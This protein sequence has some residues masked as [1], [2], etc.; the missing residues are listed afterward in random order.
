[1]PYSAPLVPP[2][3]EVQTTPPEE[4]REALHE[5][6]HGQS[7]SATHLPIIDPG[8]PAVRHTAS[9]HST[10]PAAR[11]RTGASNPSKA[12]PYARCVA[13]IARFSSRANRAAAGPFRVAPD[14]AALTAR[15][16]AFI[17]MM[18]A[19]SGGCREQSGSRSHV[20]DS[21]RS[22][23]TM[24]VTTI[25]PARPGSWPVVALPSMCASVQ[26]AGSTMISTRRL[27]ARPSRVRLSSSGDISP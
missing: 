24:T 6:E 20:Q 2:L 23:F 17:G 12:G 19:P 7:R 11:K 27:R 4:R 21:Y 25:P 22:C 5:V 1:M 18:H 9:Q 13:S 16:L 8:L 10:A 15:S 14:C 26:G 3:C